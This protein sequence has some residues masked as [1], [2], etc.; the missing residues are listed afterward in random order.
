MDN[1]IEFKIE[2]DENFIITIE[3]PEEDIPEPINE[4]YT[5]IELENNEETI[6]EEN[7]IE[8][9]NEMHEEV[10]KSKKLHN[11]SD[12]VNNTLNINFNLN[13][14]LKNKEDLLDDLESELFNVL[15]QNLIINH[16]DSVIDSKIDSKIGEIGD[17]KDYKT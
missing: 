13:Q 6:S 5:T 9:E 10:C 4:D 7:I 3:D 15:D 17:F 2:F 11:S 12:N 8:L 16:I 1:R 14:N